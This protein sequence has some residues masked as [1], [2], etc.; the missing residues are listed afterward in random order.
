MVRGMKLTLIKGGHQ[1]SALPHP[2][3]YKCKI[4]SVSKGIA[5]IL[6]YIGPLHLVPTGW[7][8]IA[9]KPV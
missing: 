9:R 6:V 3:I 1:M 2:T 7:C 5:Q 8:V 4:I